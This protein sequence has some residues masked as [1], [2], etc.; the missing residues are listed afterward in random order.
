MFYYWHNT[1]LALIEITT[2]I[3]T[4]KKLLGFL[5]NTINCIRFI[6]SFAL[7]VLEREAKECWD[8]TKTTPN[9]F[10]SRKSE[11]WG[12]NECYSILWPF[13]PHITNCTLSHAG[14]SALD[15]VCEGSHQSWWTRP[16][17]AVDTSPWFRRPT[18]LLSLCVPVLAWTILP[19]F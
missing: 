12:L 14:S 9:T 6:L 18:L 16:C 7:L 4:M 1:K 11:A 5:V 2:K 8:V 10:F 19:F 13:T 15:R 17:P 3:K